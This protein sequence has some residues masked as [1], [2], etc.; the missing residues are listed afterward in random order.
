MIRINRKN[1]EKNLIEK[2]D[3]FLIERDKAIDRGREG[4]HTTIFIDLFQCDESRHS[5]GNTFWD[6]WKKDKENVKNI[7]ENKNLE[8]TKDDNQVWVLK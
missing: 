6:E 3:I 8:L 2:I 7:L 4:I 1:F 5:S